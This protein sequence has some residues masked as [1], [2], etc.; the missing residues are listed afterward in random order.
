[1]YKEVECVGDFRLGFFHVNFSENRRIYGNR[2][3]YLPSFY[4]KQ[5]ISC[6]D[7]S[8]CFGVEINAEVKRFW[9]VR[10]NASDFLSLT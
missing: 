5:F 9:D 10:L 2:S 3:M 1:M 8:N 6:G 7:A 4:I